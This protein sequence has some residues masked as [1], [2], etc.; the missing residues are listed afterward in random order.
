[1]FVLREGKEEE[2]KRGYQA[3]KNLGGEEGGNKGTCDQGPEQ[4]TRRTGTQLLQKEK[5]KKE[6]KKS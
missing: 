2:T 4:K 1:M 6:P 3:K 5:G